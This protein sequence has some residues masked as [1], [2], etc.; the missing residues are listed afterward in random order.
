MVR[1]R[2]IW[3]LIVGLPLAAL[4][5]TIWVWWAYRF[6]VATQIQALRDLGYPTNGA[7]LDR[8]YS[9]PE[10]AQDKTSEWLAAVHEIRTQMTLTRIQDL[11]ILGTNMD[12]ASE[13]IPPPNEPWAQFEA[14]RTLLRVDARA[15]LDRLLA[16]AR[17]PGEVRFPVTI[18]AGPVARLPQIREY[19][20][21]ARWLQLDARVRAHE[22]QTKAIVDDILV[23]ARWSR[24]LRREPSLVMFLMGHAQY[25]VATS[26][27]ETWLSHCD[28]SDS[29]L[30]L[31]QAEFAIP[32]FHEE[33]KHAFVGE[34]AF[35]I[36]AIGLL[37]LGPYRESVMFEY[38][39]TIRSAINGLEEPWP[40]PLHRAKQ[41]DAELAALG[42]RPLAFLRYNYV[43]SLSG[44][45]AQAVTSAARL[46]ARQRCICL[47]IAAQRFRL[48]YAQLP[49]RIDQLRDPLLWPGPVNEQD[50]LDPFSGQELLFRVTDHGVMI[51]SVAEDLHDD[52]GSIPSVETRQIKDLG[53][54]LYRERLLH[55]LNR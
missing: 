55:D 12:I 8:Y 48:R 6:H 4:G 24:H 50:F 44:A 19:R 36:S 3:G 16:L 14:C 53:F 18:A 42:R 23:I 7:E 1:R 31:L 29:D 28:W 41:I 30:A 47:L 43:P 5:I 51:Y 21:I 27:A 10:G 35:A 49:E 38:L 22:G 37:T 40:V 25:A 32:R 15:G 39:R 54:L 45:F 20:D 17:Q 33:L 2:L 9:V 26:E 13:N 11:P 34:R 46:V 52:G